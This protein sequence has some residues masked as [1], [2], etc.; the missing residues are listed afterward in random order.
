MI[1]KS[2]FKFN[3]DFVDLTHICIQND[4]DCIYAK[5]INA[6][7]IKTYIKSKHVDL[8]LYLGWSQL[9]DKQIL[10]IPRIGSIGFHPAELPMNRGRH[11]IIWSLDSVLEKLHILCF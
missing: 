8:I 4:I 5:D 11:P 2:E 1:T 6:S 10:E 9:L 7:E 3:A